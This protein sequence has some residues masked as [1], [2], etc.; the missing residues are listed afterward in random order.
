MVISQHL[1]DKAKES[2]IEKAEESSVLTAT[3]SPR[4]TVHNV[5]GI[6][7]QVWNLCYI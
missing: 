6:V 7:T 3:T 4:K 2:L 5:T 1:E